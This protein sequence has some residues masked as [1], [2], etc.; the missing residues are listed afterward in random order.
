MTPLGWGWAAFV[1]GYALLWFLVTD[2]VKLLAYR[3]FDPVKAGSKPGSKAEPKPEGKAEAK[4]EGKGAPKPE[5]KAKTPADLKGEPPTAGTVAAE[6]TLG[7][8]DP[9]RA[10]D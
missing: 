1:W 2:P 10:G 9:T 7:V 8:D 3:I 5:A 4:P 6:G